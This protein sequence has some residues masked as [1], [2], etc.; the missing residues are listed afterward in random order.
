MKELVVELII[1]VGLSLA[2]MYKPLWQLAKRSRQSV[3]WKAFWQKNRFRIIASIILFVGCASRL[4]LIGKYPVG[5]NQDEASIG[6][7]A[8]SILNYGVDRN[9]SSWP[10]HLVSWGSG[11]NALYAYL[12]MPFLALLGRRTLAIRLP[13]AL[14]GCVT[15]LVVYFVGRKAF[16]EK[17]GAF[18]LLLLA[19]MPWHIMKSRWGLE[20]NL[21]PDMIIW[22]VAAIYYGVTQDNGWRFLVLASVILGISTYAYGTSY[23]FVP[24]F[25]IFI[26]GILVVKKYLYWKKALFYI[27]LVGII[28]LPMIAF[29]AINY[30]NLSELQI[31]GITI[32][33]LDYNRFTEISSAGGNLLVNSF[34][35]WGETGQIVLTQQ[36]GLILNAIS[37]YGIYYLFSLPFLVV[38]IY[39]AIRSKEL[40][41]KLI[42]AATLAA[43]LLCGFV[44][45]NI[46]RINVLWL[47]LLFYIAEGAWE[48]CKVRKLFAWT[49]LG[50]YMGAFVLFMSDYFTTYQQELNTSNS[51]F[52]GLDEALEYTKNLSY[53]NLYV[54]EDVNQ[55][56]IYYLWVTGYNPQ[57]YLL[58]RDITEREVM[59]QQINHIG[60]TYFDIP[61][62]LSPSN[63][64]IVETKKTDNLDI[65]GL[66][67]I[68]F[69]NYS[70][71][72][73]GS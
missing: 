23:L 15:L 41:W 70:V 60:K 19:V 64:Y 58:D 8:F 32:P 35:F 59:F 61:E 37:E 36:D 40:W 62:E 72:K 13:M 57:D 39:C 67:K 16:G 56:Y 46:N 69:G 42:N 48:F 73:N 11:Q 63:V 7:E 68:S 24:L 12:I 49:V 22:A 14:A 26:F 18:L 52:N 21:F 27:G 47:P 71:L 2:P 1:C 54:S 65:D 3:N 28:A 44:Q 55:P 31:L 45:P 9:G 66:E 53:N 25:C 29:V 20:S 50:C 43:I 5:L 4:V 33:K 51:T 38:G 10:V 34:K 17:K 6:Y 30:F